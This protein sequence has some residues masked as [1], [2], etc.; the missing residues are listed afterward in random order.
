MVC[1][2]V[3]ITANVNCN[4]LQNDRIMFYY[5]LN[6]ALFTNKSYSVDKKSLEGLPY[7]NDTFANVGKMFTKINLSCG[8]VFFR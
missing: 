6:N 8:F 7:I 4:V 5:C 2:H 1:K 3:S